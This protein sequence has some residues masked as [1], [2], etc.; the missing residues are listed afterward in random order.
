MRSRLI[1]A[2]ATAVALALGF[3]LAKGP[4]LLLAADH[5]DAPGLMPPGGDL[6]LDINDVYAFQSPENS[7]NAVVIMTVSPLAIADT[8]ST[9]GRYEVVVDTDAD[10][11]P[12]ATV[13]FTFNAPDANGV[14]SWKLKGTGQAA[15]LSAKGTTGV[16]TNI[17]GGG[18]A[19][20][21]KFD[22]PFFFDLVNFLASDFS[23]TDESNFF[24]GANTL[25]IVLEVPRAW[26]AS[27]HAGIW[28]RTILNE[29]Q[30]DRMARPGHQHGLYS[31]QHLRTSRFRAVAAER[32]QRRQATA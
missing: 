28:A 19:L 24:A 18:R 27:D 17:S 5:L 10:A 20:A 1:I 29:T 26:M 15:Q 16:T 2:I 31:E 23:C 14:Q 30:I 9:T 25:G 13:R 8:F 22:D 21:G 12:D 7:S 3:G 4:N 11:K 6:Q 32:L